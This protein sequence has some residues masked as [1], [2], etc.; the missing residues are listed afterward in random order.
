MTNTEVISALALKLNTFTTKVE[1]G[2]VIMSCPMVGCYADAMAD[3]KD[4]H[5]VADLMLQV[6]NHTCRIA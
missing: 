5:F 4:P 1:D 3:L 6:A 2:D